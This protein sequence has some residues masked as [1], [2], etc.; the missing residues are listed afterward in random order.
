MTVDPFIICVG[1]YLS[2]LCAVAYAV[3]LLIEIDKLP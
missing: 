3:H 1:A 2:W